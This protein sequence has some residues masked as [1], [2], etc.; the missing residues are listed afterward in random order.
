MGTLSAVFVIVLAASVIQAVTGF[1]FALVAM[2]L[3][4]LVVEPHAAVVGGGLA[5]LLMSLGIGWRERTHVRWSS[6][7][8]L[9]AATGVGMPVGLLVLTTLD[10]TALTVLTA[11]MALGCTI[12]VWRGL[13]L[14]PGRASVYG[15]G[16]VSGVL[17]TATGT[18]G[19]PLV[20]AFQAM[21][22]E[23]REFRATLAGVFSFTSVFGVVGFL[24]AGQVN[25]PSILVGT[26]GLP[27]VLLGWWAGNRLFTRIDA[28]RFRRVVLGALIVSC[29]VT[30]MKAVIG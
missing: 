12:L 27:A 13:R 16:L 25:R 19:P 5:S 18:N 15:A 14:P 29:L 10:A 24:V 1:G 30:V 22:Y 6:A 20:A 23:P 7:L 9:M 21:R 3:L 17:T 2:P 11:V 8:P 26:I 28:P 4:Q